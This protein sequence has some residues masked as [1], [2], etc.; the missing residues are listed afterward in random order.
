MAQN[1]KSFQFELAQANLLQKTLQQANKL[2][3]KTNMQSVMNFM[4]ELISI[5]PTGNEKKLF[6]A[7]RSGISNKGKA[8][9]ITH[10][11]KDVYIQ[12]T[13]FNMPQMWYGDTDGMINILETGITLH[14]KI[15]NVVKELQI[16]LAHAKEF[17]IIQ[18]DFHFQTTTKQLRFSF[19]LLF[20]AK[21]YNVYSNPHSVY[22][23]A[24]IPQS[25]SNTSKSLEIRLS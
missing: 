2:V 18:Q 1:T 23:M 8:L 9:L 19:K 22:Q 5:F 4:K 10:F 24:Y 20:P 7:Y 3:G 21:P 12:H 25:D 6:N 14:S 17:K 15:P 16:A 13:K 11:V